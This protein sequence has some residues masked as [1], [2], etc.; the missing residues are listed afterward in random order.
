MGHDNLNA[1]TALRPAGAT[2]ALSLFLDFAPDAGSDEVPD[3]YNGG[4]DGF[5]Q[6]LDLV[7]QGAAGLLN[8]ITE[9]HV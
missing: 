1:L 7:E 8:A 6:V 2:A 3:P 4:T 9:R 5:E